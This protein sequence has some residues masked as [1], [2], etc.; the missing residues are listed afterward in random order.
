M[1]WKEWWLT[2]DE[3]LAMPAPETGNE[4]P[5]VEF[6]LATVNAWGND[7]GVSVKID[8]QPEATQK[9][10]KMMLM[11]RPLHV[12]A[13]VVVMKISGSY[14][15]LGEVANPNSWKSINDL[16]SGASTADIIAK[17]NE[18]IAWMRTQGM[19]WTS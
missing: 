16:A 15:V 3:L 12:G 14:I 13:R 17:V 18:I 11:C 6:Y 19:V 2:L 10:Y 4:A 5:E 1:F 9:R 7:T 8:G